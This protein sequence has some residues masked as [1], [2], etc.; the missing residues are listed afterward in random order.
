MTALTAEELMAWLEA[1]SSGWRKLAAEHPELLAIPCDVRGTTNVA[2]LLQHIVAVELR[3]TERLHGLPA[4]EY[5]LIPT[6]PV[7]AIYAV[8]DRAMRMLR[9]L[10]GRDGIAWEEPIEVVTRSAGTQHATRRVI[11]VHAMMHSIR[12]YAQLATLVRHHGIAPDWGM[13]YLFMQPRDLQA[14]AS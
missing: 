13:D 6:A 10:L 12:H 4:T 14:S 9:E 7:E 5:S 2:E 1:T 3:F 8:H 11:L